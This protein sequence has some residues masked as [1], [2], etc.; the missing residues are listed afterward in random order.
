MPILKEQMFFKKTFKKTSS[1]PVYTQKKMGG[2]DQSYTTS[3]EAQTWDQDSL[4][5]EIRHD[6]YEDI[7]S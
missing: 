3:G 1:H 4:L 7:I 6:N 2:W 5:T